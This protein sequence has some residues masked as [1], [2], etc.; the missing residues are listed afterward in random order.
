MMASARWALAN[1]G[2]FLQD[3]WTVNDR[4]TLTAACA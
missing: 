4:L 3:T 1:T 2:L